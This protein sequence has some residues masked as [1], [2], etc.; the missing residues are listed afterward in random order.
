[1]TAL[2]LKVPP[3]AVALLAAGLM[4]L[5]SSWLPLGFEI[6]ARS[7]AAALIA[8]LGASISIAGVVSFRRAKTTVNPMRVTAASSLVTSGVFARTRNP[9][10]LGLL[11]MLLGW[12]VWLA[13]FAALPVL[14]LF[15]AYINRFQIAPEERALKE[16]FGEAYS[17]YMTSTRRWL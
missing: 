14:P 11:V 13:N 4:W 2:E 3:P 15:V 1:M 16:I 10:Y 12:S 9:M 6:P 8:L 5:L 17:A 7:L